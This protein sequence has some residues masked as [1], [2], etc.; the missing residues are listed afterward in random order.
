[1]SEPLTCCHF[2]L[3]HSRFVFFST[4]NTRLKICTLHIINKSCICPWYYS[5]QTVS[6]INLTSI[7]FLKL[8]FG[9]TEKY[10]DYWKMNKAQIVWLSESS[11]IDRIPLVF[12]KYLGTCHICISTGRQDCIFACIEIILSRSRCIVYVKV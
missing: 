9:K 1:M 10:V 7:S 4:R 11:N 6:K 3:M 5:N 8:K 12:R 2:G